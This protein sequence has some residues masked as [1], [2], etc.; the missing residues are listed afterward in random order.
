M[1]AVQHR[2]PQRDTCTADSLA[3]QRI[4][5]HKNRPPALTPRV[6]NHAIRLNE[7][8]RSSAF[9]AY[10]RPHSKPARGQYSFNGQEADTARHVI[11]G[12]CWR[13]PDVYARP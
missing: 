2:E 6:N 7:L 11:L 1:P 12:D 8:T 4:N 3:G 9:V 10:Y 13:H 5:K